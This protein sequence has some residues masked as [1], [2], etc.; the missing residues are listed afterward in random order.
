M[1][2]YHIH[3]CQVLEGEVGFEKPLK[4]SKKPKWGSEKWDPRNGI[5]KM[6]SKKWDS[7]ILKKKSEKLFRA[8]NAT[9]GLL[10]RQMP[11]EGIGASNAT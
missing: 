2:G 3:F 11:P 8:S 5:Q 1:K 10:G 6:E 9:Q 7:K 4:F